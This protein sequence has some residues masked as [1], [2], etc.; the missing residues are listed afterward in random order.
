MLERPD[1]TAAEYYHP[2]LDR[3]LVT[4]DRQ[5]KRALSRGG[6]DGHWRATGLSYAVWQAGGTNLRPTCRFSSGAGLD[7]ASRGRERPKSD[8]YSVDITECAAVDQ[9]GRAWTFEG[10]AFYV[11]VPAGTGACPAG[12]RSVHRYFRPRG[13]P[14]HRYVTTAAARA[15]MQ[16]RGW[17][18]EGVAWCAG[19]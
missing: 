16:A 7:A 19:Q 10:Y 11:A 18:Y 9:N 5:E 4:A 14:N 3:Y 15:Q 17:Q 12:T 13:E 8:F 2:G 6:P 1:A